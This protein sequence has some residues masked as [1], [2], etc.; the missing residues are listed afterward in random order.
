MGVV[1]VG[2]D[3]PYGTSGT[4]GSAGG[5]SGATWQ[6]MPVKKSE[7]Y[8]RPRTTKSVSIQ[9][10]SG[11]LGVSLKPDGTQEMIL[12]SGQSYDGNVAVQGIHVRGVGGSAGYQ[13]QTTLV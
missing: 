2:G 8:G 12:T 1:T 10:T 7:P 9:C 6:Q 5:Y 4:A 3:E 11:T 13:I